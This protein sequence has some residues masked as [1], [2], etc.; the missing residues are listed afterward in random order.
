MIGNR[1]HKHELPRVANSMVE[2][3]AFNRQVLG[4][5][6]RRPIFIKSN[7]NITQVRGQLSVG[8]LLLFSA[9]PN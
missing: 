7:P 9:N 1:V 5:N 4:S 6:P 8:F 2:Y 3:P